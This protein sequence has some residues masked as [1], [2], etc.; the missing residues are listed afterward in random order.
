M[1]TANRAEAGR[2][3][4][5]NL[6]IVGTSAVL[7]AA[8]GFV[9]FFAVLSVHEALGI[10]QIG[11]VPNALN[12][13]ASTVNSNGSTVGILIEDP[14]VL[15]ERL[16]SKSFARVISERLHDQRLEMN[17]P[18]TQYGG[19]GAVRSRLLRDSAQV[20][21]RIQAGTDNEAIEV[22]RAIFAELTEE[23]KK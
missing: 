10:V 16:R 9:A 2:K 18:A 17:L 3:L 15:V 5:P 13:N 1:T 6:W 20:E 23:H 11:R 8:F 4:I 19:K 7:G 21:V 12:S 22:L 14:N